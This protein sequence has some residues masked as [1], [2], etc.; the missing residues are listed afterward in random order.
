MSD[1]Q[2][3][4]TVIVARHGE[5]EY[6]TDLM[7]D[8]GGSL[9]PLG[10][11]QSA[12]LAEALRGRRIATI[13]CSEMSRAVQ[14]AEIVAAAKGGSVLV[15]RGLRELSVGD[16]AGEPAD[17]AGDLLD[18][19][20]ARWAAGDLAAGVPGG[21]TGAAL[22]QRFREELDNAADL[23]R[24]ETVLVISHGAVTG[25]AL[26]VM[27]RNLADDYARGHPLGNCRP[28]EAAVDADGWVLRSWNGEPV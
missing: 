19:I 27:A 21:E 11:A 2:C 18:P 10:R 5:A 15:R 20:F 8:D 28:C 25:L 17:A 1:L 16:F 3:A 24:G 4:A 7:S 26:P 23:S 6:E 9:T 14:T 22:V 12:G 13:W